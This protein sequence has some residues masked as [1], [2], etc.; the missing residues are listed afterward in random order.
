LGI[1]CHALFAFASTSIDESY[2]LKEA[3]LTVLST[4]E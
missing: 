4:V 2:L 3:Q 1:D